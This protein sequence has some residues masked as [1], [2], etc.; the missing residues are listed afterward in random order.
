MVSLIISLFVNDYFRSQK[1]D[2]SKEVLAIQKEVTPIINK[3]NASSTSNTQIQGIINTY[4]DYNIYIL[5]DT[6]KVLLSSLN[7][8]ETQFDIS[9]LQNNYSIQMTP[10]QTLQYYF[11]T[12]YSENKYILITKR[13]I[14]NDTLIYVFVFF[15]SFFILF[16]LL[17]YGTTKYIKTLADTLS[18]IASG[19]LDI[20]T[21]KKGHNELTQMAHRIDILSKKLLQHREDDLLLQQSK[22]NFVLNISHDLRTPLTSMLGYID[23]LTSDYVPL[24]DYPKYIS[25]ISD[26]TH[27][28]N[29]LVNELFEYNTLHLGSHKLNKTEVCLNELV[30]QISESFL[31]NCEEKQLALTVDCPLENI[32]IQIDI[33]KM[34]RVFENLI[35]NA[36]RYTPSNGMI[37]ITLL[38]ITSNTATITFFNTGEV[39]SDETLV[40]IF[41]SYYSETNT[42]NTSS[43]TGLG[44]AIAKEIVL[45]H[46][47]MLSV[48]NVTD[49]ICFKLSLP[50]KQ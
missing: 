18:Q 8:Y 42:K 41:D 31:P 4:T 38:P 9:A 23:L 37:N 27:R 22:D 49:G 7:H 34:L 40:H 39:L 13:L 28:L 32:L 17:T 2:F 26:K 43:G 3:L 19:N 46:D 33:N 15:I 48:S 5:N 29:T 11:L 45:L 35:I 36:I 1:T 21:P 30:R 44:L 16:F 14:S 25:I 6:G 47:G 24:E 20:T 10:E 12:P 50:H